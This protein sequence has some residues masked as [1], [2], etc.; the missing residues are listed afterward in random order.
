MIRLGE[1]LDLCLRKDR[2]EKR[3]ILGTNDAIPISLENC[4]RKAKFSRVRRRVQGFANVNTSKIVKA[5]IQVR[6]IP[7]CVGRRLSFCN[8]T[9]ALPLREDKTPLESLTAAFTH[10]APPSR[11]L[12]HHPGC[13]RKENKSTNLLRVRKCHLKRKTSTHRPADKNYPIFRRLN[14]P[15]SCTRKRVHIR[16]QAVKMKVAKRPCLRAGSPTIQDKDLHFKSFKRLRKGR[17]QA[18]CA[19]SI[20]T[21]DVSASSDSQ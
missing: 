17:A 1:I 2:L 8:A 12:L 9:K 6:F 11:L 14:C 13:R 10:A 5:P 3:G 19:T 16:E 7:N 4:N 18:P 21:R 15:L 20:K